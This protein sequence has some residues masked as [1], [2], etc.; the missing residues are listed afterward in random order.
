MVESMVNFAREQTD[1]KKKDEYMKRAAGLITKLEKP[2]PELGGDESKA[3]FTDL[4]D[5]EPALKE[6]YDK[7]KGD[8]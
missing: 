8:K 7:L 3:R 6:Q 2:W 4:L 5:R 1:D